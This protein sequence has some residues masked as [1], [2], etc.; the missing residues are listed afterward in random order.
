[1]PFCKDI[2][3]AVQWRPWAVVRGMTAREEFV[4]VLGG[5]EAKALGLGRPQAAG[6]MQPVPRHSEPQRQERNDK[7]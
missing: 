5:D 2:K 1:M 7:R 6:P 3:G 4:Y